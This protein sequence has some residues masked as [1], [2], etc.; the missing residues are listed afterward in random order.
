M[1]LPEHIQ[2]VHDQVRDASAFTDRVTAEFGQAEV[3]D[4]EGGSLL[5]QVRCRHDND[6]RSGDRALIFDL[7]RDTGEFQISADRSLA[8]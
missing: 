3:R 2:R 5:V 4:D 7:D 8:G 1:E 6:F